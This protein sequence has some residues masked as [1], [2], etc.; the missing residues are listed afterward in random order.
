MNNKIDPDEDAE[1]G[2]TKIRNTTDKNKAEDEKGSL[3]DM[4]QDQMLKKIR[5]KNSEPV[6]K[7]DMKAIA[8][9]F[10]NYATK[11]SLST[12]FFNIALVSQHLYRLQL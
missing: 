5:V 6:T 11:K 10:N 8:D 3:K 1:H 7:Y 2:T 9:V 4:V 12:G